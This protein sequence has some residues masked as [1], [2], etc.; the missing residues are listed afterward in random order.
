MDNDTLLALLKSNLEI[1]TAN[2]SRNTFMLHLIEVAKLEIGREGI[3]L[4]DSADDINLVVMYAAWLYRQRAAVA[5]KV[6][7]NTNAFS[8]IGMPRMLRYA[9]NNRKLQQDMEAAT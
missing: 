6:T 8:A 9:L 4:G 2:T 7:Y 3:D 5:D 1:A